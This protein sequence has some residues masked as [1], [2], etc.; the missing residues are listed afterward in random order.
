MDEVEDRIVARGVRVALRRPAA[1][2]R[3]AFCALVRENRAWLARWAPGTSAETDPDGA[4]WFAST[5]EANEGGR[6]EKLLV[7]AAGDGAP[8]G[9]FNLNEIV[10]GLFQSTYLGYWIGERHAG[11]GLM[12]EA[13]RLGLGYAF[14]P[15]GL[16]RA[17][18]N[19]QPGNDASIALVR[20][21]GFVQ[22]GFSERYLKIGG[23]WR[24]HERWAITRERW[25][26]LIQK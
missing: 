4:L 7:T 9:M 3:E 21:A 25:A 11:R 5:L 1:A 10:R 19:I 24:D 26:S 13:L 8:L 14:G 20:S 22:E 12:G 6:S 18:A 15:L 17:E 2:D 23:A 16:H